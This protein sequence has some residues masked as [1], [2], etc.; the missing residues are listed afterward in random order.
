[1]IRIGLNEKQ[2]Q[3]EIKKYVK[4]NNIKNV[5]VF[6]PKNMFMKLP[7]MDIPIRQID[8]DEIIMYRTFYPLL[9]EIGKNHLL[10]AN[11]LMRDKNRNCLTYN[12]YAKYTNQT[13]HRI[14]FNYFPIISERKDILILIDFINSQKYKG[15]GI[16]DIDISEYD[17]RC[18]RK[19]IQLSIIN[20]PL[21]DSANDAYES[22][23]ERL[24]DNLENK[25]PDTIPRNLHIWT[26]KFKKHFLNN[27]EEYVARNKRFNKKN[28]ITYKSTEVDKNY[29]LVDMPCRRMEFNDFLQKT[30]QE[31]LQYISTG[32]GVDKVY[33]KELED[34]IEEVENIYAE[35]GIYTG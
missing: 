5:I 18:I 26:G 33:I 7:K 6:S 16:K 29:I 23:K 25:D 22:E 34:W 9:E 21:P 24:F 3:E 2:K 17:I 35:T 19:N 28:V 4:E 30:R 8:Y 13:E 32:F 10:I 14:A 11:E 15:F 20:V 27:E 31:N 1:M 12:S